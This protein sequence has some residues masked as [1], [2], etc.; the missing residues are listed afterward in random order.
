[1]HVPVSY[2][3]LTVKGRQDG[4]VGGVSVGQ[5]RCLFCS[6]HTLTGSGSHL[7][8]VLL[9][10][11]CVGFGSTRGKDTDRG[12]KLA[13]DLITWQTDIKKEDSNT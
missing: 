3:S 4:E 13:G 7:K 1:M 8:H 6:F 10:F 12:L 2:S 9:L 5:R 11:D